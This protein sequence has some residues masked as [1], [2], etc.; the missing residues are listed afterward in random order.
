MCGGLLRCK[1]LARLLGTLACAIAVITLLEHLTGWDPG[2]DTLL[3]DEA[4]GE[5]ATARPGRMG[6]PASTSFT[7]LGAALLML[8]GGAQAR[9]WSARLALVPICIT[10]LSLTG[11]AYGASQFYQIPRLTGIAL[12]T[13]TMILAL[14]IGLVLAVPEHGLGAALRRQDSGGVVLRRLI[15]PV[16]LVPA[17]AGGL[18][19]QGQTAGL[20]DTQFGI[21]LFAIL[22]TAVFMSLLWWTARGLSRGEEALRKTQS[23]LAMANE[24]LTARAEQLDVMV[25]RRT[26]ELKEMIGELEAFSY[27]MAHDLRGPLRAI[28]GFADILLEDYRTQLDPKGQDYLERISSSTRRMHTLISDV[29][30]YSRISSETL[31]LEQVPLQPLVQEVVEEHQFGKKARLRIAAGLP[32]VCGNR[33]ALSQV[34]SNLISNAGKFVAPGTE[35]SIEVRANDDGDWVTLWV[36]DNGLGIAAEHQERIFRMFERVHGEKEFDGTGIGLA[37]VRRAVERMG[38]SVGVQSDLGRGSR[39]WVKLRRGDVAKP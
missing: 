19:L 11:Y 10:A 6:P 28:R 30:A 32:A 36:S 39:F 20:Y 22:M 18:R 3:F 34:L 26:A 16:A 21:A 14:G 2:L 4:P 29:L 24:R 38:G 7:I 1:W 31:A 15:L 37:I 8:T 13:A 35:P 5:L 12:Q 25:E 27:S 9:Q 33:T 17:L 23:E